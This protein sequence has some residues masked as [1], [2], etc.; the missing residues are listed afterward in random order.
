MTA[1]TSGVFAATT[2]E[3]GWLRIPELP[4]AQRDAWV[5][6]VVRELRLA[7]GDAWDDRAELMVPAMLSDTIGARPDAH[8][9]F[10]VWP[11]A[12]PARARVQISMLDAASVPDLQALGFSLVPYDGAAMGP[13]LMLVRQRTQ[14]AEDGEGIRLVDWGVLFNDGARAVLV[15]VDT[16]P[17]FF[18]QRILPG[19][20]GLV[21]ALEAT[22]P[23]GGAFRSAPTVHALDD[24]DGAWSALRLLAEGLS[25]DDEAR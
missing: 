21:V 17:L 16:L 1:T 13:G 10:E 7:W 12:A 19:L 9:V 23:G 3:D 8:V 14:T 15:Q 24:P 18:L 11:F 6:E 2:T 5:A 4:E 20:H 25:G 22:L